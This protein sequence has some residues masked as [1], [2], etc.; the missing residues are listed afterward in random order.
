MNESV[1][2]YQLP[3]MVALKVGDMFLAITH[4]APLPNVGD[5]EISCLE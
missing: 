1:I 5:G 2:S 3:V 4:I